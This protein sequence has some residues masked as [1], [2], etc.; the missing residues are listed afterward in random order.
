MLPKRAR[1]ARAPV[2][3]ERVDME[4]MAA[5]RGA[6]LGEGHGRALAG[7]LAARSPGTEWVGL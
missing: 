7:V 1:R 4:G 3:E 6:G 2:D 5:C